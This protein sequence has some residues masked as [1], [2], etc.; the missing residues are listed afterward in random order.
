MCAAL[1]F[2]QIQLDEMPVLGGKEF[3]HLADVDLGVPD[4]EHPQRRVLGHAGPIDAHGRRDDPAPVCR[5]HIANTEHNLEAR[6]QPLQVPFE[7]AGECL[8]K[9]VHVEDDVALRGGELAEIP[10]VCVTAG[11]DA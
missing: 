8:V 6:R 10:D 7:G 9:V 11:L 5:R 4:L 2:R 1:G 3:E